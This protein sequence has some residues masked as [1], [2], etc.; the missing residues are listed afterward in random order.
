MFQIHTLGTS[1]QF[2][3]GFGCGATQGATLYSDFPDS[4]FGRNYAMRV[5]IRMRY[6]TRRDFMDKFFGLKLSAQL[7]ASK[8]ATR[9]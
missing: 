9:W 7:F 4:N 3:S 5:W 2:W 8:V 1:M 6:V